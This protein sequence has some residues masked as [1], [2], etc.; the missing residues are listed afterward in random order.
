MKRLKGCDRLPGCEEPHKLRGS[1]EAWQDCVR[2]HV[3]CVDL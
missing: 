1:M 3:N 2:N